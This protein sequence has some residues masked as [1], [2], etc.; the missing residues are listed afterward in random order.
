MS[1]LLALV[2]RMEGCRPAEKNAL[3]AL[4]RHTVLAPDQLRRK[5]HQAGAQGE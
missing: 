3:G 5:R 2:A 1:D 4:M